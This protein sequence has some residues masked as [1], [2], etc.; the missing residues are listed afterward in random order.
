[1][2]QITDLLR[3]FAKEARK[4]SPSLMVYPKMLV[5][6]TQLVW[7][8]ICKRGPAKGNTAQKKKKQFRGAS[9]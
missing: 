6:P 1:M 7:R 4:T 2:P 3:R 9:A 5:A 8:D